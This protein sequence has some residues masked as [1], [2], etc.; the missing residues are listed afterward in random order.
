MVDVE[1]IDFSTFNGPKA[2]SEFFYKLVTTLPG[3]RLENVTNLKVDSKTETPVYDSTDQDLLGGDLANGD[4]GDGSTESSVSSD[5]LAVVR[6]VALQGQSLLMSPEYQNLQR[7]GFFISKIQWSAKR[8]SSPY[9]IVE[10]SASFDDPA[11]GCG[12]VYSVRGWSTQKDGIYTKGFN[13]IPADEKKMLMQML[14]QRSMALFCEL[15]AKTL[16]EAEQESAEGELG[17]ISLEGEQA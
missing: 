14:E 9:Q 5:M 17:A 4:A 10:F 2:K 7:R 12:F 3:F 15:R 11:V 6:A 1:E 8:T 16:A 13:G